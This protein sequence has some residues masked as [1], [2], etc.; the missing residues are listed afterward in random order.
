MILVSIFSI[1]QREMN[2]DSGGLRKLPKEQ[3]NMVLQILL[4]AQLYKLGESSIDEILMALGIA[5]S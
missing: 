4:F 5:I 2:G 1:I 3:T